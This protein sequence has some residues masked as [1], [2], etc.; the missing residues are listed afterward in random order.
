[1]KK[2]IKNR[3]ADKNI[4]YVGTQNLEDS[5]RILPTQDCC[6]FCLS[7]FESIFPLSMQ[8]FQHCGLKFWSSSEEN[9]YSSLSWD[10]SSTFYK[11]YLE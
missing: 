10:C 7:E 5:L 11:L 3:S 8:S 2:E 4:Y 6:F 1:M 9:D